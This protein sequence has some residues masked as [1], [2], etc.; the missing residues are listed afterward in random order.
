MKNFSSFHNAF[1]DLGEHLHYIHLPFGSY[2]AIFLK[3]CQHNKK[4]E[5]DLEEPPKI[6][7]IGKLTSLP[8]HIQSRVEVS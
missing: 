2:S 4:N 7:L 8:K 6:L 5:Q 3:G 1:S